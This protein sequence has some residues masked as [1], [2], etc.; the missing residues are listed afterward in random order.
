MYLSYIDNLLVD[1]NSFF[2]FDS[3]LR[4]PFFVLFRVDREDKAL[5][6]FIFSEIWR[7]LFS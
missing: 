4:G 5:E 7:A 3:Y 1:L 2:L 6:M